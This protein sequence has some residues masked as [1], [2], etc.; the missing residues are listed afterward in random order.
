MG[1]QDFYSSSFGV[2]GSIGILLLNC[3]CV[4]VCVTWQQTTYIMEIAARQSSE[5][6]R[7]LSCNSLMWGPIVRMFMQLGCCTVIIL[8]FRV[9]VQSVRQLVLCREMFRKK[10]YSPRNVQNT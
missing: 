2:V 8:Q 7:A 4:C 3:V 6:R 9:V 10:L 1:F 5:P